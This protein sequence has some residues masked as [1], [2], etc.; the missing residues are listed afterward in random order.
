MCEFS[1]SKGFPVGVKAP[2]LLVMFLCLF[3]YFKF[4]L[5]SKV[6]SLKFGGTCSMNLGIIY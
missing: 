4:A 2:G 5:T 6:I 3:I 1:F